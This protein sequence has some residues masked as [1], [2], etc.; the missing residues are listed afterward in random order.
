M[1]LLP[2]SSNKEKNCK[3]FE[4]LEQGVSIDYNFLE[5]FWTFALARKNNYGFETKV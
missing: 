4:E 5:F 2:L 1:L 3:K